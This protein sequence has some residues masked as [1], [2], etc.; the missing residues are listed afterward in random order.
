MFGA[1]DLTQKC[2]PNNQFECI[3]E[4]YQETMK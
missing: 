3:I 2:I 4:V 1:T